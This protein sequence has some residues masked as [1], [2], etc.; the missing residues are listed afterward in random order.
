MVSTSRVMTPHT[1]SRLSMRSN[2]TL[3]LK[4][5]DYQTELFAHEQQ[6]QARIEAS[7]NEHNNTFSR[8]QTYEE[9]TGSHIA[10][11][12][13]HQGMLRGV[14]QLGVNGNLNSGFSEFDTFSQVISDSGDN[15][16]N[17]ASVAQIVQ[18]RRQEKQSQAE[19][20]N[21]GIC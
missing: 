11:V 19:M 13:G 10:R 2:G 5:R 16:S 12:Q 4:T 14:D 6:Q 18:M 21:R 3:S 1:Q 15:F 20:S 7:R 17:V 9:Y 8:E